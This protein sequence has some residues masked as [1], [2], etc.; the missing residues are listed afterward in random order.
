MAK[1]KKTMFREYDLRGRVNDE[2]LN[3]KTVEIIGRG[4]GTFLAKRGVQ[5]IVVGYDAREYS[6]RLEKALIR[7]ILST[8]CDIIE[9]GQLIVPILYFSQYHFKIKGIAMVTASHNPNGWSGFKLGYD[10][11]TTLL[12]AEIQELYQ[13]IEKENF[14]KGQGKFKKYDR[15]I[16][17]YQ[18]FIVT[19]IKI[20]KPFKIVVNCGNG[21]AGP[22]VPPILRVVGC[23]VVEQNC[24]ID[25]SFPHYEPN[26][27]ALEFLEDLSQ[28]VKE[29]KAGL[30]FGFDG[31]GDRL[32]V[33]DDQGKIVWPDLVLA[34]LARPLL[35]NHP[36]GKVV[37]DVKSS[38][39][40][41]EDIKAHGGQPI[42]WITGHS[43]LKQKAKE[44]KA[45][46]AGEKSGHLFYRYDFFGYD[47][48]LFN[49]LKLLE[50]LSEENKPLS[51]VLKTLPQY[52]TSPAWHLD[53]PDEKKYQVVEKITQEFKKKFGPERVIDING[54]RV[55][56]DDGW[57]LVRASSNL[58]YLVLVFEAKTE[59]RL[60]EIEEIFRQELEKYPE[61]GKEWKSG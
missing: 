18:N 15:I 9:M 29:E 57:G 19:K 34:L 8:G 16:Q 50:Y 59:K 20:A 39:A 52:I 6:E 42:I 3:E 49:G 48:A 53:C 1:L 28:K 58:P 32:G 55:E 25:F 46:I 30:G 38:R 40:L 45:I 43:Y 27:S 24:Q 12:S 54:A 17:D 60:K 26:P 41:I 31:D 61:V 33:V 56:F 2:E 7:G 21:T 10:Y 22:I 44:V 14:I 47:D 23:Q 36:G 13:I 37:F 4:F 51:E 5:K 11:S 35:K